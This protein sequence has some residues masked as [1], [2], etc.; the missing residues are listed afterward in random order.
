M[1]KIFLVIMFL[2]ILSSSCFAITDNFKNIINVAGIN[3]YN[4]QGYEINEEIYY[5]YNQIVY[6][7]PEIAINEPTQRWKN[8]SNGLWS[9]NGI[10]GEYRLLGYNYIGNTVNNHEFPN[11]VTPASSPLD[12][13]YVELDDA[14]SSW[15][16]LSLFKYSDLREYMK[17]SNLYRDNI[18]YDLNCN[19]I[20]L[21]KTRVDNCST[22]F[23]KG[24]VYTNRLDANNKKW[25]ATFV[26]QP[27]DKDI[28]L[29][30]EII[31]KE[32]EYTIEGLEDYEDIE[33]TIIGRVISSNS[34]FQSKYIKTIKND[35][36]IDNYKVDEYKTGSCDYFKKKITIR[37]YR[38][39]YP[40]VEEFETEYD[41]QLKLRST[42][43]SN[44]PNDIPIYAKSDN[45]IKLI[46]KNRFFMKYD[47]IIEDS[48]YE[49]I[50]DEEKYEYPD[51]IE[52]KDQ[53]DN[54]NY[55]DKYNN[56]SLYNITKEDENKLY[57][58]L[59]KTNS[60]NEKNSYGYIKA[61]S[62]LGIRVIGDKDIYKVEMSIIG[63]LSIKEFD[64]KTKQFEW[65]EAKKYG[66][67]TRFKDLSQYY[68]F[69]NKEKYEMDINSNGSE[70]IFTFEYLIP[71]NTVQTLHS[72]NSIRDL[73]GSS[74]NIDKD[75]I[76][77]R[78]SEPYTIKFDLYKLVTVE[79]EEGEETYTEIITKYVIFDV[80]ECW[81]NLYNR[82]LDV[83]HINNENSYIN[84][85]DW[86]NNYE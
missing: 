14:L 67:E 3:R 16:N 9:K 19:K 61:G 39:D 34:E 82:D 83:Y 11:D 65:D 37:I 44:F 25:E 53:N 49:E 1:K 66:Y 10:K 62:N 76:F 68:S 41:L 4:N 51:Y 84:H 79:T 26:T 6:G 35:I 36:Y 54:I 42:C 38:S 23:S 24:I 85:K 58:K 40:C 15:N 47:M 17:E 63:D 18:K 69:Y 12:W 59:D 48:G 80:F 13:T 55:D 81:N 43:F 33:V 86:I 60:T 75:K 30:I 70:N 52:K 28:K 73:Y 71:Y 31:P 57:K 78:K 72:W 45:N 74:F 32:S 21:N 5:K 20:G 56:I 46:V 27:I 64:D 50:L 7:S 22:M 2:I 29:E 77:T 8:V